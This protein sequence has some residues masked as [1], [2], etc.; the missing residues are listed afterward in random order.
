MGSFIAHIHNAL[1]HQL[2]G[3]LLLAEN[4]RCNVFRGD[5]GHLLSHMACLREVHRHGCF[6]NRRQRDGDAD[7]VDIVEVFVAVIF[8]DR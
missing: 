8:I 7:C 4:V 2:V 1:G 5:S 6:L 3:R